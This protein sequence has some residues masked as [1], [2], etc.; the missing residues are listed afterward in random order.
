MTM[1]EPIILGDLRKLFIFIKT[2]VKI[3]FIRHMYEP[4]L[5]DQNLIIP[6]SRRTEELIQGVYGQ[7]L[8][9]RQINNIGSIHDGS[10]SAHMQDDNVSQTSTAKYG[11][12]N[13]T[14]YMTNDANGERPSTDADQVDSGHPSLETSVS[15][16]E[17]TP[18]SAQHSP[19]TVR[20][21]STDS[22]DGV[23]KYNPFV[24]NGIKRAPNKVILEPIEHSAKE[25]GL[26]PKHLFAAK[27][28]KNE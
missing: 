24:V 10:R 3:K 8:I 23:L 19:R 22:N 13:N 17:T 12:T 16:N 11:P 25:L 14:L 26:V 1:T 5:P 21:I 15:P 6:L 20:K 27:R 9:E 7:Y 4:T 18:S 2:N 28:S